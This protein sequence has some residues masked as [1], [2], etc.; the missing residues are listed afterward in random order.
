VTGPRDDYERA[1]GYA[2]AACSFN[3]RLA[4]SAKTLGIADYRLGAY[5]EA[6]T[7][8][9]RADA[10]ANV[11]FTGAG[12]PETI[13]FLAMTYYRLGDHEKAQ[14]ELERL[15]EVASR[16]AFADDAVTA[17]VLREAVALIG[18]GSR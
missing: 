1:R 17:A 7:A 16:Q 12:Q 2:R 6:R 5:D 9:L 4:A 10:L 14:V 13:G 15:R 11:W 8:L 3:P 18:D